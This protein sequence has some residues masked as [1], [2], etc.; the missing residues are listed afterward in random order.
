MREERGREEGREDRV[1][2]TMEESQQT[3]EVETALLHCARPQAPSHPLTLG[4]G[5]EVSG[6]WYLVEVDGH[7]ADHLALPGETM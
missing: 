4:G 3:R 6:K 5:Q 7:G 1:R 2:K